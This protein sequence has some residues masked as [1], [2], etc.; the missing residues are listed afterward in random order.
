GRTVCGQAART[1]GD[2]AVRGLRLD[3]PGRHSR[4][5]AR[6]AP[7]RFPRHGP[8]GCAGRRGPAPSWRRRIPAGSA[9]GSRGDRARAPATGRIMGAAPHDRGGP[10]HPVSREVRQVIVAL[11]AGFLVL[12]VLVI[13]AQRVFAWS[14]EGENDY[15]DRGAALADRLY[16]TL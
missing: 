15:Y 13:V 4:S 8:R 6:A 14:D 1:L 16:L 9:E 5:A 10:T 3:G 2:T 11:G 7:E 12:V